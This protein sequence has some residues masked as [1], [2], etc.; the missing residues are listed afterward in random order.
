M[1]STVGQAAVESAAGFLWLLPC[2]LSR[3]YIDVQSTWAD[4]LYSSIQTLV[5]C[6]TAENKQGAGQLMAH[7]ACA[8]ADSQAR[9]M[10]EA[11]AGTATSGTAA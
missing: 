8:A 3:E 5:G 2:N 6:A 11:S 1:C 9:C 7:G 4:C 10:E